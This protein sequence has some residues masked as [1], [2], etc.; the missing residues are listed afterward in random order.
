MET[1]SSLLEQIKRYYSVWRDGMA[2][3][4]SWAEANGLT[5]NSLLVL[6]S[7]HEEPANCTQKSISQSWSMPKQ[8]VNMILKDFE[9]KGFVELLPLPSDKRNKLIRTT[10]S[11]AAFANEK[12]LKFL[13]LEGNILNKY[14]SERLSQTS[15]NIELFTKM[16]RDKYKKQKE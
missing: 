8:T 16:L 9:K 15:D 12:I 13:D 6:Y 3:C 1:P 11:G 10:D 4:K 14:G 5:L 2:F 7:L